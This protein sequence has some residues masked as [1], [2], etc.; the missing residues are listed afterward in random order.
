MFPYKAFPWR[1]NVLLVFAAAGL[2]ALVISELRARPRRECVLGSIVALVIWGIVAGGTAWLGHMGY[3]FRK[4]QPVSYQA[5]WDEALPIYSQ[6]TDPRESY[7]VIPSKDGKVDGVVIA[8]TGRAEV[9]PVYSRRIELRAACENEC[10]VQIGQFYYSAWH[11][12]LMPTAEAVPLQEA[13]PCV[14]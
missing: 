10:R 9:S 4:T 8:G 1:L 6:L 14:G 7:K 11:A 2:T 5:S 13:R 3:A 12:K